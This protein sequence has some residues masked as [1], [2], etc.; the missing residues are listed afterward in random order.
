MEEKKKITQ[1]KMG[2]MLVSARSWT[3]GYLASQTVQEVGS[4]PENTL[5]PSAWR[6]FNWLIIAE[7]GMVWRTLSHTGSAVLGDNAISKF[8]L[9]PSFDAAIPLPSIDLEKRFHT[10]TNICVPRRSL[11]HCWW[12]KWARF[13]IWEVYTYIYMFTIY[14]TW[15]S[16][17]E[18]TGS[19]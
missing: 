12:W 2:Q 13:S 3:K 11:Q 16:Y 14:I 7:P 6:N 10:C 5:W 18:R 17:N 9:Q 4:V 19:D 1:F 8:W 15:R